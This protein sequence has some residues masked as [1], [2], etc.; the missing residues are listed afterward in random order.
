MVFMHPKKSFVVTLSLLISSILFM[1]G[2]SCAQEKIRL[3]FLHTQVG[4]VGELWEVI[5]EA[6]ELLHPNVKVEVTYQQQQI[7][8][9]YGLNTALASPTPP[10]V[11]TLLGDYELAVKAE[12]GFAADIEDLVKPWKDRF[13]EL[14]L[15]FAVINGRLYGVPFA[16][17]ANSTTWYNKGYFDKFGLTEPRTWSEFIDTCETLKANGVTPITFGNSQLWS[18]GNW[19]SLVTARIIGAEKWAAV[20]GLKERF[21]QSELINALSVLQ[22]MG[23]AGY[24]NPDMNAVHPDQ[25]AMAFLRGK[26]GMYTW[27]ESVLIMYLAEAPEGLELG[28]FDIPS[29]PGSREP[30]LWGLLPE[31]FAV[32]AKTEHLEQSVD[33]LKFFTSPYNAQLAIEGGLRSPVKRALEWA[34]LHPLLEEIY[35]PLK[36]ATAL[37]ETPDEQ[38]PVE[39]ADTFYEALAMVALG[40][41]N[42]EEALKWVDK[43]LEPRRTR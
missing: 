7:Y 34:T 22:K 38:Y 15:D 19:A 35:E 9:D 42:P 2:I 25:G 3:R 10:D 20:M 1:T 11:Y 30:H 5:P 33:F 6:Y 14:P 23:K 43:Q 26:G 29:P 40:H 37:I 36:S 39:V 24:F 27:C 12:T 28:L 31:F 32:N 41:K 18:F 21:S 17:W 8:E 16:V 13:Q 4:K